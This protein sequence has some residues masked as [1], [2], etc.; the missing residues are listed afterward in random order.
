M[1]LPPPRACLISV[2]GAPEPVLHSLRHH[3]PSVVAYFCS[4]GSRE[5]AESIQAQL[6]FAP[7]A[8]FLEIGAHE[9]LGPCYAALRSWLPAW[10]DKHGLAPESVIV[11]YTGGTKTMSAALVLAATEQFSRFSYVGGSRREKD[12][13][14]IVVGG[15]ERLLGDQ[16]NPWR[17]LAVRELDQAA[18]LWAEQQ[19]A[20][21]AMLLRKA[22]RRVPLDQRPSFECIVDLSSAL[23]DRLA[24]Q[25]PA[26]GEKLAKL[27]A[28]LRTRSTTTVAPAAAPTAYDSLLAFCEHAA[29][30]FATA[31][32]Q[33]GPASDSNAQLRELLDNALLTARLGRYDDA[34]ARLYRALELFGQN[35]LARLTA[36]AFRLGQLKAD[37]L[38]SALAECSLF[39]GADGLARARRGVALEDVYRVLAHLGHPSGLRAVADFD[40]PN[41]LKSGWRQATQ[42]RNQSILAHGLQPVGQE[43]FSVLATLVGAYTG[44]DTARIALEAPAFDHAWF[45]PLQS[46]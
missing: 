19:Y 8:D 20:A 43:G 15:A 9:E 5:K 45:T 23:A 14:G 28:K 11:D 26:A 30:R 27:A 17:E 37:A 24:L 1:N 34:S 25:L 32:S 35:E 31:Q 41:A 36:G 42:R 18:T 4:A 40:S 21:V 3:R 10:L 13:T 6:D 38:P 29:S 7:A 12:G 2:G 22:K 33:N 16:P 39:A 46:P 44:Q